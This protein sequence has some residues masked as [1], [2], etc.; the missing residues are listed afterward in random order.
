MW[1]GWKERRVS[2]EKLETPGEKC[3]TCWKC[4]SGAGGRAGKFTA[5][6]TGALLKVEKIRGAPASL[7]QEEGEKVASLKKGSFA[8][9]RNCI[10]FVASVA[11][12]SCRPVCL[13][14]IVIRRHPAVLS[15][16]STP[17]ISCGGACTWPFRGAG[18]TSWREGP[19]REGADLYKCR[20]NY[21]IGKNLSREGEGNDCQG[22]FKSPG[23]S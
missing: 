14:P 20:K 18:S 8:R 17:R 11:L 15:A 2:T 6:E 4:R 12:L 10:I 16:R 3:N 5:V 7:L 9:C 23:Y 22:P 13:P 21:I 19:R 1:K